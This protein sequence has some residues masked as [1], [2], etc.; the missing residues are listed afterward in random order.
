MS[1]KK[2]LHGAV[3][4]CVL[5]SRPFNITH[6]KGF[7]KFSRQIL[8]A[9]KYF[10]KVADIKDLLP[11]RKRVSAILINL[12]YYSS[13]LYFILDKSRYRQFVCISP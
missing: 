10:G 9:S 1:F 8:D 11:H 7:E 5:D 6:G 3:K 13:C 12:F 4:M 2:T